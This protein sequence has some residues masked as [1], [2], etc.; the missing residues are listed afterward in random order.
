MIVSV[1]NKAKDSYIKL[2]HDAYN[3]ES[4]NDYYH[5]VSKAEIYSTA[6]KDICGLTIWAEIVREA[7]MS[8]PEE[9]GTCCGVPFTFKNKQ[10]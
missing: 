2:C 3:A 5:I 1:P 6:I 7:D 10:P 8:F 4:E 9:I